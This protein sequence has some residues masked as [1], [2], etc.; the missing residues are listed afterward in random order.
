MRKYRQLFL[1]SGLLLIA[2]LVIVQVYKRNTAP[3]EIDV[4][5]VNLD[6][7]E[8][9]L[10]VVGRARTKDVINVRVE[11]AGAITELL[12]DEGDVVKRGDKIAQLYSA[13]EQAA[14]VSAQADLR[15][16]EA[17]LSFAQ[18]EL[19]RVSALS[20]NGLVTKTSLDEVRTNLSTAK[21]KV[22][23]TKASRN[24]ADIRL[25]KFSVI[26][27][28]DGLVLSR[29]NDPGQVVGL[30][31][32]LYEIGSDG[33][34]EIE[35]EVDEVYAAELRLKM[36]AVVAPTGKNKVSNARITEISPRVNPLNGSR[37]IRLMLDEP[38]NDFIPGR[39]IDIN[40]FVRSFKEALSVPRSALRK[41][42]QTWYV[43]AI[44]GDK[45][46]AHSVSFIDWPGSSVVLSSGINSG[47]RVAREAN[48]AA[49]ALAAEKSVS[50]KEN[51]G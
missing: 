5:N 18:Q 38:N 19:E 42:G 47:T 28:I 50:A 41:E 32:V 8:H 36:K 23:V 20:K 17:Q 21:A 46:V 12:V 43:Y 13:L 45:I 4:I 14:L 10:A 25:N 24:Q 49:A 3:I 7:A 9:V 15:A 44:E 30:S 34:I 26:S 40:I 33:A 29:P 48:L 16:S 6:T 22:D 1:Y 11:V 27:P 39:S 31:D 37:L 51:Q 35:A 2:A